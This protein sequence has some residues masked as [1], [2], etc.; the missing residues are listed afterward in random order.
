MRFSGWKHRRAIAMSYY[1]DKLAMI[2]RW[3]RKDVE[4]SNFYYALTDINRSHLI[5]LLSF[6]SA[7]SYEKI[8]GYC[9]ELDDDEDLHQHLQQALTNSSYGLDIRVDYG[10]R[11]GWYALA[12]ATK[13]AVVVE[14]GVDHGVGA[15]VL[16]SALLRNR[17]EGYPGTYFGTEIRPEAGQLLSGR[18]AEAGKILYGDSIE[19]LRAFQ[20]EVDLFVNDSDHSADYE[21]REYETVLSKLSD[22]A[23]ILGD[24]AHVTDSLSRFSRE[25]GR[26]FLFFHEQ[27]RDH[28]YPGAGIGVSFHRAAKRR[29]DQQ[30]DVGAEKG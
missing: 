4:T 11:L 24:N 17:A 14:T 8:E 26:G 20:G 6:V 29:A 30:S 12:R 25:Q 9:R 23:I 28:W 7:Q 5:H 18:Y 1:D 3:A 27:P 19:T 10:R 15:C 2:D 21:Y 22:R 13:P 16:A